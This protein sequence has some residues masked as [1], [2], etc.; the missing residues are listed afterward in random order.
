MQTIRENELLE[1]EGGGFWD[2]VFC[3]LAIVGAGIVVASTVPTV[4]L[5]VGVA[6]LAVADAG[7]ICAYAL[8]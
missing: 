3:G 8:S 7:A 4:A 2:G 6:A 5:D 1:I